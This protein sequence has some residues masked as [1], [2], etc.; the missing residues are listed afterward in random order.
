MVGGRCQMPAAEKWHRDTV[1]PTDAQLAMARA[2]KR[3]AS[4]SCELVSSRSSDLMP[5]FLTMR[6]CSSSVANGGVAEQVVGEGGG[7]PSAG[8]NSWA[9]YVGMVAD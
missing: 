6:S 5:P 7:G 1:T 2:E 3:W 4:A 8:R 9:W